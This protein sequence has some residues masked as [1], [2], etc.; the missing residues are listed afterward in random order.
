MPLT[1]RKTRT[2]IH[3]CPELVPERAV[4]S[5]LLACCERVSGEDCSLPAACRMAETLDTKT[6]SQ[7]FL[8]EVV[9]NLRI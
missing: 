1:T 4:T 9:Q 2:P 8:H 7:N 6:Y 5:L 3:R